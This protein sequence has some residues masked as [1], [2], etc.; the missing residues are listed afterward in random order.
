MPIDA[1]RLQKLFAPFAAVSLKGM[2]GGRGVYAEGV[3]FA[4]QAGDKVYLKTDETTAPRFR[5]AGSTPFVYPTPMGPR[6]TSYW[7]M[8]SEALVDP[9]ALKVWCGLAVEAARRHAAAKG[10]K[11]AKAPAKPA[12][13]RPTKAAEEAAAKSAK[14]S[15]AKSAKSRAR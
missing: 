8:P 3:I 10:D 1:E 15:A 9:E 2:F 11:R 6:E 5:E 12:K 13:Q 4:L 7:T 14:K